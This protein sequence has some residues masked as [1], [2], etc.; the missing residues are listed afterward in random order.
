M[1]RVSGSQL[2]DV[3]KALGDAGIELYRIE[4]HEVFVAERVRF[5]IMDSGIR[6][7]AE[8]PLRV[9]FTVRSQQ[10][11]FPHLAPDALLARVRAAVGEDCAA[12][13]FSEASSRSV[14]VADPVD[15]NKVLDVWH[16][17]T[18]EKE[19]EDLAG[20]IE[21]VRWALEI[22]KYVKLEPRGS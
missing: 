5:H 15:S 4:G 9:R 3:K 14:K 16:E 18:Y 20:A 1:Y 22:E 21:D 13:G 7:F 6:V 19:T 10:S 2:E 12:R 8:G 11:D 17:V